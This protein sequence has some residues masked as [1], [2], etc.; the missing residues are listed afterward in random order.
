MALKEKLKFLLADKEKYEAFVIQLEKSQ[1]KTGRLIST[2]PELNEAWLASQKEKNRL[3]SLPELRV[4]LK[5]IRSRVELREQ[6]MDIAGWF[7]RNH[8]DICPLLS[9]SKDDFILEIQDI[10]NL[11]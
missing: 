11:K 8:P 5:E 7:E 3:D 10:S 9:G 6:A 1:E 4:R 2:W